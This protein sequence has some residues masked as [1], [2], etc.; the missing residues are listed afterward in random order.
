[1]NQ[2]DLWV[3]TMNSVI[4]YVHMYIY[5]RNIELMLE[6]ERQHRVVGN[7]TVITRNCN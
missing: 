3:I 7:E 2:R 5:M 1:V 6:K 4:P